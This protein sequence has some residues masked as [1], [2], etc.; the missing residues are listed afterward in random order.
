MSKPSVICATPS[1][2]VDGGSAM[3]VSDC[4]KDGLVNR[5]FGTSVATSVIETEL[6]TKPK[7]TGGCQVQI[8]RKDLLLN[9][10]LRL[11]KLF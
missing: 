6:E 9:P 11:C 3:L 2:W 10:L 1:C 8:L 5:T 7:P 4:A